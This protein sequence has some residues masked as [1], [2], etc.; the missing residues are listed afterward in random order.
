MKIIVYFCLTYFIFFRFFTSILFSDIIETEIFNLKVKYPSQNLFVWAL[1]LNRIEIAKI[2][3]QLGF[4]SLILILTI[5][6]FTFF[7][8]RTVF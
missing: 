7:I 8:S 3:W 2:F 5:N 6:L 4:V 1:L